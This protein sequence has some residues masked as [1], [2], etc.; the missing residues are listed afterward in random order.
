VVV[1]T[2]SQDLFKV[3]IVEVT[4]VFESERNIEAAHE[5]KSK[6]YMPLLEAITMSQPNKNIEVAVVV[7]I[8][9]ARGIIPQFWFDNLKPLQLSRN[10]TNSLAKHSSVAAIQGSQWI[11]GLGAAQAHGGE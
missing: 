7:V 3:V 11:W 8:V 10:A 2:N 4:V 5:R 9:G 6:V 1:D